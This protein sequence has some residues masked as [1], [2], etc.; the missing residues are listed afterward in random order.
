VGPPLRGGQKERETSQPEFGGNNISY[1]RRK[2][3]DK[4]SPH[5]KKVKITGP[6]KKK[7]KAIP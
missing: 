3:E 6:T 1:G 5:K 4:E 7:Q 2:G